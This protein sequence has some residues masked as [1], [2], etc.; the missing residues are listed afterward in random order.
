[1]SEPEEPDTWDE[2]LPVPPAEGPM[3]NVK[4]Y[5]SGPGSTY[6]ASF[7]APTPP[8][9]KQPGLPP[10]EAL[11]PPPLPPA[12]GAYGLSPPAQ[13]NPYVTQPYAGRPGGF[14]SPS[15]PWAP[16]VGPPPSH[17]GWAVTTAILCCMPLGVVSIV[18]A[19]LV[20][21]RWN[22]GDV[23]GAWDA[24][25]KAKLWAQWSAGSVVGSFIVLYL[26]S[27][28]AALFQS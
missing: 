28:T 18:Y 27:R 24:S 13:P 14:G 16:P 21:Q 9:P 10:S 20:E 6:P 5:L 15:G 7:P 8:P 4:P 3:G 25:R 11:P 1:M 22:R 23:H 2:N 26:V 19:A 12:T 17:M